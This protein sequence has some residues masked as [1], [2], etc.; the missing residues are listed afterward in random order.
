MFIK[1]CSWEQHLWKER[2]EAELEE[3]EYEM[4][5]SPKTAFAIQRWN[6]FSKSAKLGVSGLTFMGLGQSDTRRGLPWEGG[7][8]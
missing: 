3:G 5:H 1:K 4:G 6:G 2:K 7:K 8:T